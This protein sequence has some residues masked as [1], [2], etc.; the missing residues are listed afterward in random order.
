MYSLDTAPIVNEAEIPA[1]QGFLH[2]AAPKDAE[3]KELLSH[4]W[5]MP[6]ELC[7]TMSFNCTCMPLPPP[8]H[9]QEGMI[10]LGIPVLTLEL[11][12]P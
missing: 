7:N 4:S 2:D 1:Q 3:S 12:R 9:L 6:C 8:K 11:S 10:H 5:S